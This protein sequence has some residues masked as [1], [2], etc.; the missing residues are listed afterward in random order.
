VLASGVALAAGLWLLWFFVWRI[1]TVYRTHPPGVRSVTMLRPEFTGTP[2]GVVALEDGGAFYFD[3][4]N[5][6]SSDGSGVLAGTATVADGLREYLIP[7][8]DEIRSV[9]I[10]PDGTLWATTILRD[11]TWPPVWHGTIVRINGTV[12]TTAFSIPK[13][14]GYASALVVAPDRTLWFALP[15]A[16]AVG[17]ATRRG[18]IRVTILPRPIKPDTLALTTNGN[19]YVAERGR[20]IIVRLSPQGQA[21]TLTSHYNVGA[22]AAGR[23]NEVWFTEEHSNRLGR[24]APSARIEE[25]ETGSYMGMRAPLAVGDDSVWFA[26]GDG[27]GRLFLR[28]RTSVA[29]ALPQRARPTTSLAVSKAGDVWTAEVLSDGRCVAECGAIVRI[30]P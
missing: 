28:D 23:A 24:I 27:V 12:M 9:A 1:P 17:H 20:P 6:S 15:D 13:R 7:T 16:H 18:N 26:A 29:I 2:D 21:L 14:L 5:S 30:V 11:P 19:L 8:K 10:G 25:F 3:G 22:L 4:G